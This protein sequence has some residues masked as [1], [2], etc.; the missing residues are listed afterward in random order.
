MKNDLKA[1]S[2]IKIVIISTILNA[3]IIRW[4]RILLSKGYNIS[5]ISSEPN[6]WGVED[7]PVIECLAYPSNFF[8]RRL[9][10]EF[11]RTLRLRRNIISFKPDII[12]LHS[13]DYIH[14]FMVACVN[15]FLNGFENMII[16]TWGTDV[17]GNKENPGTV[18]GRWSKKMLLRQAKEITATSHFLAQATARL[19]P[20][21][22]R[23]HVI[24]FGIDCNMFKKNKI[25]TNPDGNI[26]LGFVKHLNAK[27]G[28]D[29]LLKSLPAI[30]EKCPNVRLTLVGHGNMERSLK[31]LAVD[32]R[33]DQHVHFT[34]YMQYEKIPDLLDEIDIF[35]MPSIESSETFG[36]AAIEAQAMEIPV[37]ASNIGGVPEALIDGKTGILVEPGNVEQLSCAII[38]LIRNRDVMTDMGKAGRQFVLENYDIE[39]N[40]LLFEQIYHGCL[41]H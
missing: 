30:I 14:P 20:A 29:I 23:I 37:V 10:N 12:H 18:L 38:K 9:F 17:I 25:K 2:N 6:T 33:V 31:N 36:V 41:T 8:L 39:K 35:V 24:P 19:S 5:V 16:S 40:V 28:P 4:A 21:G 11:I 3:H 26:H 15:C 7:I 13:L 1:A 34:G 22:A 27:Y 32:L